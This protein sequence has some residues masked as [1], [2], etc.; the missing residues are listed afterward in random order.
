MAKRAPRRIRSLGWVVTWPFTLAFAAMVFL[1]V[2]EMRRAN[3]DTAPVI[4]GADWEARLSARIAALTTALERSSL[5]LAAPL[6]EE[7]GSGSVRY[8]HRRYEV[9]L[10]PEKQAEAEVAL[11]LLHGVDP[12]MTLTTER[13]AD[14]FEAHLGLDGLLTH[15][16]RFTWAQAA[17]TPRIALIVGALGDDLRLAREAVSLDLPLALAVRP[18]RPFSREVAELGRL[19]NRDVLLDLTASEAA[20]AAPAD[21]GASMVGDV[22]AS[23]PHVVGVTRLP[24]A[25]SGAPAA[26]VAAELRRANLFYVSGDGADPLVAASVSAGVPVERRTMMWA[27]AN[28]QWTDEFGKL[29]ARARQE[30]IVVAYVPPSA[31]A[32]ASVRA[33]LPE[34]HAAGVATVSVSSL[35]TGAAPP[36]TAPPTAVLATP[37]AEAEAPEQPEDLD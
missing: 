8:T 16:V 28:A 32:I 1:T 2:D 27:D 13:Q 24:G 17:T 3:Q 29:P 15:T 37:G 33:L 14:G 10:R 20:P 31:D 18:A 4:G 30:G 22:L 26:S 25:W 6:V 21:A 11:E 36:T 35:V 9:T 7:T 12:G 5:G 19:F 23:I 34:W